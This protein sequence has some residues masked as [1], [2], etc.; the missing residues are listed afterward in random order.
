[1]SGDSALARQ[2]RKVLMADW[3]PI[4]LSAIPGAPEDEYD[5]Y[6]PAIERMLR[7]NATATDIADYLDRIVTETMELSAKSDASRKAADALVA[8]KR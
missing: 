4:G 1:M 3:D 5:A 2:I 6:V 7:Q 8:I